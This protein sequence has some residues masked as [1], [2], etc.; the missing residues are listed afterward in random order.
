VESVGGEAGDDAAEVVVPGNLITG[1]SN[2]I[3][4]SRVI[5]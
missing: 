1:G 2:K 5:G 4:S 3:W